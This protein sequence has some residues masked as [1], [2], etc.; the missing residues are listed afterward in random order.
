MRI[1]VFCGSRPG[2]GDRYVAVAR[3][4]GRT[5]AE[6]GIGLVY[7][8]SSAGTMGELADAA[9]AAGGEVIG[10]IPEHTLIHESRHH[11]LSELHVVAD[12]HERKARMAEL[13][14]GFVALPGG[15]GTLEEFAEVWTWAHLDLHAK[16]LVLLDVDGFYQPFRQFVDHMVAEGF[17]R[18]RQRDMLRI[19]DSI[20]RVLDG[21]GAP[22]QPNQTAV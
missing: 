11:G 21:F 13:A 14:D 16:P 3:R 22:G 9:L 4:L 18:P 20:D 15:A 2:R 7:G 5:L 10:V 6:R 17:V 19:D 8:G 1:C 12:M